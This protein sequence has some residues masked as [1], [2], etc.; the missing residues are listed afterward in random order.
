[1]D[2]QNNLRD[3]LSNTAEIPNG[4][5]RDAQQPK[6]G[7]V[8]AFLRR[9]GRQIA[10]FAGALNEGIGLGFIGQMA[11]NVIKTTATIAIPNLFHPGSPIVL[12][13]QRAEELAWTW[14]MAS[15]AFTTLTVAIGSK[16]KILK[17]LGLIASS[18][19]LGATSM[20]WDLVINAPIRQEPWFTPVFLGAA[21]LS[22]LGVAATIRR[23]DNGEER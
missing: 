15:T 18:T 1:M 3:K 6:Q 10:M 4:V 17:D 22:G 5:A 7:G 23:D 13:M 14:Y 11:Y 2:K 21:A 8:K 20:G 9:N 16:A 12:P 19:V